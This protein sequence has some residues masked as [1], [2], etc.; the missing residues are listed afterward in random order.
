[1]LNYAYVDTVTYHIR[2]NHEKFN[3][4]FNRKSCK[5]PFTNLKAR[6]LKS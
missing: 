4:F 3:L 6:Y 2:N 5:A 1:M